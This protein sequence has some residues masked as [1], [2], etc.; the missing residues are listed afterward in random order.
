[1]FL[2][3]VLR[4]LR[5]THEITFGSHDI[6]LTRVVHF[7]II[8]VVAGHNGDTMGVPLLPVLAT[9]GAF[10]SALVNPN[11]ANKTKYSSHVCPR[12]VIPHTRT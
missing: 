5:L 9:L 11:F 4:L 6:H 7:L 10:L 8:T 2:E 12:S 1:M 3:M